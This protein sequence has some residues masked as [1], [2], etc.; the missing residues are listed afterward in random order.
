MSKKKGKCYRCG[1]EVPDG[2]VICPDCKERMTTDGKLEKE[3]KSWVKKE[4]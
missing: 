3:D 4:W 1:E 2:G